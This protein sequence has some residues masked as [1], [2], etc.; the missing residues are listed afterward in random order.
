MNKFTK[1][2]LLTVMFLCT[3]VGIAADYVFK[4]GVNNFTAYEA[5]NATYTVKSKGKVLIETCEQ[6]F[7]IT[8]G[9]VTASPR[10]AFN[11]GYNT[12]FEV[13]AKAGD[14][15][16]ISIDFA[17]SSFLRI[18][19]MGSGPIPVTLLNVTPADNA[20]F[21]WN[22]AGNVTL[23]FNKAVTVQT[24]AIKWNGKSYSADDIHMGSQFVSLNITNGINQAYADGLKEG[25]KFDIVLT[26]VSEMTDPT[27]LYGGNGNLTVSFIAP[28]QQ[29]RLVSATIG[30]ATITEGSSDYTFRSYYDAAQSDGILTFE[31]TE[32]IKS[33]SSIELSMGNID[34]LSLG[35]YYT[36]QLN[37]V[38]DGKKIIVDLRG[39]LRSLA[40]MF[41][42]VD[43]EAEKEITDDRSKVD[44]SHIF[45]NV[46]NVIDTNGNYMHSSGQGTVGSYSYVFNYKELEDNL[47]WAYDNILEDEA[48]NEHD[49]VKLWVS[50]EGTVNNISV[51]YYRVSEITSEEIIYEPVTVTLPASSISIDSHSFGSCYVSFVLPDMPDAAEEQRVNILVS[52]TTPDGMPHSIAPKFY[53]KSKPTDG[54]ANV[55]Q[56]PLNATHR[57]NA[58]GQRVSDTAKGL[59]IVNG[60]KLIVK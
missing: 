38:I 45:L 13:D 48:V 31:F 26:G 59:L 19:E 32:K 6:G 17:M 21:P 2:I 7:T 46:K 43:M 33:V 25:N 42:N 16:R 51:T 29:G 18:T 35:K 57:Y 39:K 12:A 52:L 40:N 8:N 4:E 55:S 60:K 22:G 53:Y 5:V 47:S 58:A 28:K 50:K 54:I 9:K 11:G 3:Q 27:N 1:L 30:N 49:L 24:I 34:F 14:V 10:Q 44:F 15:I 56:Q 23:Q 20:T 36:E 41:P 37:Y